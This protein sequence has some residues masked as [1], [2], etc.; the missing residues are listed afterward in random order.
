MVT[1]FTPTF[2]RK[3]E[4]IILY[5]SLLSQTDKDFEWV[6]VDDGSADG[7]E[8]L[9]LELKNKKEINITY[10][11]QENSGKSMAH[12]KGVE[13]AKGEV[14]ICVDSDDYL[15]ENAV[16]KIKKYYEK[17]KEN[18]ECCG[19]GFLAYD[20]AEKKLIGT[21]FPKDE[22]IETYYNI[23]NK[24]SVSGDKALVFKTDVIK[25]YMFPKIDGEKF[26][27][28]NLVY[29]RISKRYKMLWINTE[30]LYKQYMQGGYSDNYFNLAKKNPKANVIL[31][32]ELYDFDKSLYNVAA[33][34]MFCMFS[35]MNFLQTIKEHPSTFK[36]MIMYFPSW[37]KYLQKK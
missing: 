18:S 22:M 27:P 33:Y 15:K 17:I 30:I 25:Q 2:N 8:E 36:A 12:N 24:C 9:M 11:K 19:L 6:V 7:T 32:K 5:E 16:E 14:F 31:Y 4:M 20:I 34:D 28:E 37:I 21:A 10:Y 23:Y 1:I 35:K 13:L 29:N 26:V 3:K